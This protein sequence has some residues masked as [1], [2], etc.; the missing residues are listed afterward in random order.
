MYAHARNKAGAKG[1]KEMSKFETTVCTRCNGSG[2]YSFNAMSGTRCFNCRGGKTTLTK[3]GAAAREYFF[4]S[5]E[6]PVEQ[7]EVG[8]LVWASG[9]AIM[10]P[11]KWRMVLAVAV[12]TSGS[13]RD[14]V[15]LRGTELTFSGHSLSLSNGNKLMAARDQ[16]HLDSNMEAALQYQATLTK[17]GKPAARKS[18]AA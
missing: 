15:M 5:F 3:R 11:K 17:S 13:I 1:D 14:G 7:I 9:A 4:N 2:H 16:N 12:S 18:K 6:M 8:M 10:A